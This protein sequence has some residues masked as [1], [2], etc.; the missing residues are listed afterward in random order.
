M[1]ITRAN[2]MNGDVLTIKTRI[3]GWHDNKE[4]TAVITGFEYYQG[5][6]CIRVVAIRDDDGTEVKTFNDVVVRFKS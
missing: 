3:R 2:D 1:K 4:F 6:D 5:D